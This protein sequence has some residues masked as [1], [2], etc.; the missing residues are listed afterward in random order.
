MKQIGIFICFII[1]GFLCAYFGWQ[2][3]AVTIV[4]SSMNTLGLWMIWLGMVASMF[5]TFKLS[6]KWEKRKHTC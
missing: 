6:V 2:M 1:G 5:G 4:Q 3:T